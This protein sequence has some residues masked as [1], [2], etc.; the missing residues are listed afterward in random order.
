MQIPSATGSEGRFRAQI[1]AVFCSEACL[2]TSQ[3]PSVYGVS[4]TCKAKVVWSCLVASGGHPHT[5]CIPGPHG[6]HPHCRIGDK[7]GT[8]RQRLRFPAGVLVVVP[9]PQPALGFT[10]L[11]GLNNRRPLAGNNQTPHEAWS[12][13][14]E[15]HTLQVQWPRRPTTP[16]RWSP[17]ATPRLPILERVLLV[18]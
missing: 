14:R 4:S 6:P 16:R 18:L 1:R 10:R 5:R 17:R 9:S 2:Q 8:H 3:I 7:G 13:A 12:A 15:V 11:S